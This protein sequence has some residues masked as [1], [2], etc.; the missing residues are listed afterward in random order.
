[1]EDLDL[2]LQDFVTRV[3]SDLLGKYINIASR[4]AGFLVKRFGGVVDDTTMNHELLMEIRHVGEHIA[5]LYET[6]EFAKALRTVMEFADRVNA[7]VDEHK[8]WDMAKDPERAADLQRICSIILEA[9]RLLTLYLKPVL[10]KVAT[11]VEAFLA[12][13]PLSWGDI[14]TPLHSQNPIKAY[15]HLMSRVEAAQIETLLAANISGQN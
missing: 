4:S 15:Q 14:H 7:F 3:N 2:N 10:P 11:G 13:N 1:M 8:P 6:R 5:A 9:F 12:I